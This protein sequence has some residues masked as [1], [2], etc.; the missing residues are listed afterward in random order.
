[1]PTFDLL[2]TGVLLLAAAAYTWFMVR[3]IDR[4][5]AP[6]DDG[7]PLAFDPLACNITGDPPINPDL[8]DQAHE[9]LFILIP[10]WRKPPREGS[11]WSCCRADCRRVHR[12]RQGAEFCSLM[13]FD[14]P[15]KHPAVD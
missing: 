10:L 3:D 12:T 14:T 4:A 5:I 6:L 8:A 11:T 1:M 15:S 7:S 9:N 2:L 13:E